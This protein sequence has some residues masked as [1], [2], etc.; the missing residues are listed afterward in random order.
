MIRHRTDVQLPYAQVPYDTGTLRRGD[1]SGGAPLWGRVRG[2]R[3][4]LERVQGPAFANRSSD[5]ETRL[6]GSYWRAGNYIPARDPLR[7]T[8]AG[9]IR[10]EMHQHVFTYRKWSGGSH[11]DREGLHT[12]TPVPIRAKRTAGSNKP[13]RMARPRRTRL[14]VQQYRGQTYSSTTQVLRG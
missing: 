12:G 7:W 4:P 5:T 1:G 6:R 13:V 11:S 9:P 2:G 3:P 8:D 14:T 10:M